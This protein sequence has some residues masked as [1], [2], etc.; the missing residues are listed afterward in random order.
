M[1]K[2]LKLKKE[3]ASQRS[4]MPFNAVASVG[5]MFGATRFVVARKA[6]CGS[7]TTTLLVIVEWTSLV[8][9]SANRRYAGVQLKN[10]TCV[11]I[12]FAPLE[13][14]YMHRHQCDATDWCNYR[15]CNSCPWRLRQQLLRTAIAAERTLN[16]ES[17]WETGSRARPHWL[18]TRVRK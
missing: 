11:D 9:A 16:S 13:S 6:A 17:D 4:H 3:S 14:P 2:K 15:C 18:L 8:A 12:V 1:K 7:C 10:I 5:E